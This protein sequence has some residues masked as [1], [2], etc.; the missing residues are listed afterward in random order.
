MQLTGLSATKAAEEF[1][2][3]SILTPKG[4]RWHPLTVMRVRERRIAPRANQDRSIE[5]S[6]S[7]KNHWRRV[8]E[9]LPHEAR[10]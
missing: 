3:R 8:L 2:K 4:G 7:I 5:S 6:A 1:N 9:V 10:V